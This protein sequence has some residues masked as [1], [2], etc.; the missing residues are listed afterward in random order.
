MPVLA[1]CLCS[2]PATAGV[3]FSDLGTGNVYDCCSGR[4][5]SGTGTI[6][7]SFTT[8][9]GFT[10]SGAGGFS[11]DGIDLAV[12]NAGGATTFYASIWTD[13]PVY[14]PDYY[15]SVDTPGTELASWN[16]SAT[17][18]YA[19]RCCNLISI[20]GITGLT[21]IGG[22]DYFMVL[23][24]L[25]ISDNSFNVW[26]S[27]SW[28]FYGWERYSNDGGVTWM[29]WDRGGLLGAFDINGTPSGI[30]PEPCSLLLLGTGL[31]GI[32]VGAP[33]LKLNR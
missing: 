2:L 3:L 12:G 20:T 13:V 29:S 7:T 32:L 17:S 10:V 31:I 6:G 19:G 23:G 30:A 26:N 16:L 11:V 25:S 24:P 8:A 1:L 5:V 21:L 15:W 14:V 27:N 22:Q 18:G 28:G 33:R 9:Y 4:A